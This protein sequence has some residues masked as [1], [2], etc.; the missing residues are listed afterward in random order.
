[1]VPALQSESRVTPDFL[2]HSRGWRASRRLG[3]FI[4]IL[5]RF[6]VEVAFVADL[7]LMEN[8]E[9]DFTAFGTVA[10]SAE[11]GSKDAALAGQMSKVSMRTFTLSD[12]SVISGQLWPGLP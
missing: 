12:G 1:M 4:E 10:R 11:R 6:C 5:A 9:D 8:G 7:A 3:C 2:M